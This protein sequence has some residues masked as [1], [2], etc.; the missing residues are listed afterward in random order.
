MTVGRLKELLKNIND[1][2]EVFVRNSFNICGNIAD[3]D[4][5]EKT[6]YGMFGKSIPCIVLNS[7]YSKD[8]EEDEEKHII[9]YIEND[10]N[11]KETD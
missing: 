5:V 10:G 1:N 4:Q 7:E 11:K 3:L 9:D 8:I 6:T 2:T